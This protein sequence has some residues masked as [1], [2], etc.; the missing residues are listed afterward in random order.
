MAS[1][2]SGVLFALVSG[3]AGEARAEALFRMMSIHP[4]LVEEA[5]PKVSRAVMAQGLNMLLFEDL[6]ARVPAAADYARDRVAKGERLVHDHGAVRTV[7]VA[8]MG[9]LPA[10]QASL[11]RVLE[12]LGYQL[13]GTYPLDRLKMTGR[14][15]AQ[16]DFPEDIAQFFVS[17]LH[18]ERFSEGFQAAVLRVTGNSRD[19][20][21]GEAKA[22]LDQFASAGSVALDAAVAAL[23]VLAGCFDRQ[24]DH[25]ALDDY[26]AL[27]AESAEMAWIATE[28]NAFNH[29]T[30]RVPDV[31][32]LA[33][34]QRALGR[35]MKDSVEVSQS[36][37]VKQTAFKAAMV[38]RA[39]RLPDGSLFERTVPGSFYE[40]ITRLPLVDETTG[41]KK[42]DLGFDSSNAQGIF[43]MTASQAR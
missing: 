5:G 3:V 7:A 26:E 21:T 16:E 2:R 41:A 42:L 28:G 39:F 9:G 20:L 33:E 12:P 22:V 25:P 17:E 29:A 14:S 4:A 35:P 19:P 43:K 32:G 11:V 31:D 6:L 1:D 36:G 34:E 18:P 24:H 30:D 23:P 8:G 37:R 15:Y 10:G 40:F 27:K 13:N 38:Q